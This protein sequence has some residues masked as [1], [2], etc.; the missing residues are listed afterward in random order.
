MS[1]HCQIGVKYERTGK[2][3]S[4]YCHF[5][6]YPS[7]V[8]KMLLKHYNTQKKME[9]LIANDDLESLG[10]TLKDNVALQ[11][12]DDGFQPSYDSGEDVFLER[13]SM[14][15]AEY[16]YLFVIYKRKS[17]APRWFI[18]EGNSLLGF[19][20]LTPKICKMT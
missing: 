9:A 15:A 13:M 4:I 1:T 11:S 2:V 6:G 3:M 16:I 18:A 12:G 8:G 19:V 5:D 20:P 17:K 7:G 14:S 10:P